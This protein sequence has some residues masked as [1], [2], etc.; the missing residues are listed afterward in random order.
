MKIKF[1]DY[2]DKIIQAI[3]KIG[4]KEDVGINE[5]V[6]L[7]DCFLSQPALD[8]LPKGWVI[9]DGATNPMVAMIGEKS[10]R[11]YLFSLLRLLPELKNKLEEKE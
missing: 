7:L 11:I 9:I 6:R 5:S 8:E 4:T 3:D 2:K 1:E 10:S